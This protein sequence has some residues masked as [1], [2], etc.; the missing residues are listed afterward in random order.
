MDSG[1]A[2]A[3][4]FCPTYNLYASLCGKCSWRPSRFFYLSSVI[5]ESLSKIHPDRGCAF[6]LTAPF[7]IICFSSISFLPPNTGPPPTQST[8]NID[9]FLITIPEHPTRDKISS[10]KDACDS[11]IPLIADDYSIYERYLPAQV[12]EDLQIEISM[13]VSTNK[14][15]VL[16]AKG[17]CLL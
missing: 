13:V 8:S 7:H 16:T 9:R 2:P 5:I 14:G 6:R 11:N 15:R 10:G 17:R 12:D 3:E 1:Q 4:I